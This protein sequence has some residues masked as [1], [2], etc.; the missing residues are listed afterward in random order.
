TYNVRRV[1]ELSELFTQSDVISLHTTLNEKTR[2]MINKRSIAGMKD[3]VMIINT[4]RGALVVEQ[5]IVD[6]CKS[7]KLHGYGSDVLE[8]EPL[9]AP[10]LFQTVDNIII[11]PHV[12]SR[13]YESV[14]RQGLRA[15]ANLVNF[16]TGN[17]D[18]IQANKF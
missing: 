14:Q 2:G 10:H 17:S 4:A 15:A 3:G 18:Y 1:T 12:G 7:G 8:Y 11:T 13:T 9:R 16:L 6:A 5:D